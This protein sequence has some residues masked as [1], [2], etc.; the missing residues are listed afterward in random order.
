MTDCQV[1][2]YVLKT[3]ELDGRL[4][5]CRLALMAWER[6]HQAQVLT[7]DQA[8]AQEM[9]ELLWRSPAGRFVPH[10]LSGTVAA[11]AAPIRITTPDQLVAGHIVINLTRR[12][13]DDPDRHERLLEIVPH[14]QADRD[15]SRSKFRF[16]RERGLHPKT[17]EIT[18]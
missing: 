4:L 1:D 11:S 16:Y 17:H 7:P 5:A 13:V 12:P 18:R 8:T 3:A 9:D 14:E 2:F 10:G 15:A 6:G